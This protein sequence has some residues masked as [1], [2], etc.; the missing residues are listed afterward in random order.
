M[1]RDFEIFTDDASF[2][3]ARKYIWETIKDSTNN[4]NCWVLIHDYPIPIGY[5]VNS[6]TAA[7]LLSPANYLHSG[8]DMVY[9]NPHLSRSD[10]VMIKQ[11]DGRMVIE[12]SSYQQ[13]SRHR[14]GDPWTVGN[15]SLITHLSLVDYWLARE[16]QSQELRS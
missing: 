8:I 6:A 9:F 11:I 14:Q 13:W 1:R 3:D 4:N 2:L 15:D 16:F 10:G 7:I 5:N 12:G